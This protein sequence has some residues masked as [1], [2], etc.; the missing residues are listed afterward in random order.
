MA[1]SH[2]QGGL[3]HR[4][5]TK[6][7]NLWDAAVRKLDHQALQHVNILQQD[8]LTA[9]K[10][11]LAVAQQKRDESLAK[12]WKLTRSGGNL[13]LRDVC[14]K[15]I[16]WVNKFIAIGDTAMQFDPV[17][18]ALPWAGVRFLLRIAINDVE[19]FGLMVESVER[20]ANLIPRYAIIEELYLTGSLK[21]TDQ[22]REALVKVYTAVLSYLL[23]ASEYYGH[24][25]FTRVVKS[26]V[27]DQKTFASTFTAILSAEADVEAITSLAD[28]EG[29]GKTKLVSLVVDQISE[30]NRTSGTTEQLAYFYCSRNPAEPERGQCESILRSL[31]RQLASLTPGSAILGPVVDRYNA[32]ALEDSDLQDL[33]PD[34]S[35]QT[36]L[37]LTEIYPITTLVLDALDECGS[38]DR[39]LLLEALDEILQKSVN[40]VKILISSR[41]DIDIVLHLESSPNVYIDSSLNLIDIQD[42]VHERLDEMIQQRRILHGAVARDLRDLIQRTLVTGAQGMF[43]W[44]DLQLETLSTLKLESDFKARLGRLPKTL[45]ESYRNIYQSIQ[46]TGENSRR[47]AHS[48]LQWLLYARKPISGKEFAAFITRASPDPN[49]K[50]EVT[51]YHILDVCANLVMLDTQEDILAFAHLSVREFFEGLEQKI[52]MFAP[53][54]GHATLATDCL[55]YLLGGKFHRANYTS[56]SSPLAPRSSAIDLDSYARIYWPNHMRL[57]LRDHG[58]LTDALSIFLTSPAFGK[59][60]L[61]VKTLQRWHRSCIWIDLRESLTSPISPI[62]MACAFDLPNFFD[63]CSRNNSGLWNMIKVPDRFGIYPI[64]I[65]AMFGS[66][67][68]IKLLLRLGADIHCETRPRFY[69][70]G[71]YLAAP[72]RTF[73]D[74]ELA[75]AAYKDSLGHDG[76]EN[77]QELALGASKDNLR[78]GSQKNKP[79]QV[80]ATNK[81]P[82]R[83]ERHG[84]PEIE[85][86]TGRS[87]LEI[88]FDR[89]QAETVILLVNELCKSSPTAFS[90]A[91][92]MILIDCYPEAAAIFQNHAISHDSFQILGPADLTDAEQIRE[93]DE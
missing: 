40:L 26:V 27:T 45:E 25:M 3:P 90:R 13:I 85:A 6:A 49:G 76:Q 37:E 9:V 54:T 18:A 34:E 86:R 23:K 39:L 29:S 19:Q 89:G 67:E 69:R 28:R 12:R 7:E 78:H 20:I 38:P 46:E 57:G 58:P 82:R 33:R 80:R 84:N 70:E 22:L 55:R 93:R 4:P 42:F 88:A 62:W 48:T 41:D 77:K 31:V 91:E 21:V 64:H 16:V 87:A 68:V 14:E 47:L 79:G 32:A 60:C 66:T 17:H 73:H 63:I 44:V 56:C 59:W 43:R 11:V 24:H 52:G 5:L 8:K 65:A 36:I 53:L 15:I 1:L 83:A 2:A 50:A 71:L 92:V 72:N 61:S 75:F 35:I 10:D 51:V 30:R 74:F 81:R